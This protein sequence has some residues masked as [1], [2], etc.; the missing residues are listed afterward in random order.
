MHTFQDLYKRIVLSSKTKQTDDVLDRL[1]YDPF[2]LECVLKPGMNAQSWETYNPSCL[3]TNVNFMDCF[4]KHVKTDEQGQRLPVFVEE[5]CHNCLDPKLIQKLLLS[6]DIMKVM[7]AIH[8]KDKPVYVLIAPAFLSQFDV[9]TDGQLRSAF[10]Q[11]GFEGV[12]EVSLFADILTLKEA[13]DFDREIQ[14]E[15]DYILTS[16]CCPMW[17][18]MIRK[19]KPDLMIHVPKSVSPM[20][21][22]GRVIKKIVPN[23]F[24]VFVGPCLAKKAEAKEEDI[25]DAID[26]VLTFKEV[27]DLFETAR[28]DASNLKTDVREH[29]SA[30]GRIYAISSGVSQAVDLTLKRLRPNKKIQVKSVYASGVP[31]MKNLLANLTNGSLQANFIEGMGC[32]G[33]C[34]GGPR[35]LI[36]KDQAKIKVEEYAKKSLY[37]TPLDNPYVIEMLQRLHF[38]SVEE[39]LQDKEIFTREF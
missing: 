6:E 33:G 20:I 21:A 1:N 7:D 10:K 30:A 32:R 24:T 25:K 39:L 26:V 36:D 34:V 29:S 28:I 13:L 18:Q 35:A 4:Y 37:K 12:V 15:K 3:Q 5:K 14:N 27:K 2:H 9:V 17:I 31:E 16:C 38:T 8:K 11:I 22:T 19:L 23:A